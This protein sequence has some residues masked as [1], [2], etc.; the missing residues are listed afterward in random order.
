M[1][2]TVG[3]GVGRSGNGHLNPPELG[4][5]LTLRGVIGQEVLRSEFVADFV[6]GTIKL[7]H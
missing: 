4:E 3:R 2:H 1:T 6:E 7:R 5:R